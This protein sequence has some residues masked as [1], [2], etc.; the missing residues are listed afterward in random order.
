MSV[1][2][3]TKKD[4]KSGKRVFSSRVY[5]ADFVVTTPDGQRH[6]IRRSTG[7]KEK[8]AAKRV[9]AHWKEL[10]ACGELGFINE[11]SVDGMTLAEARWKFWEEVAQYQRSSASTAKNLEHICRLIG[12]HVRFVDITSADIADAARRRANESYGDGEH[13]RTVTL[14]TVNRQVVIPFRTLW[15]RA[16]RVW[17]P[18]G[19]GDE[20]LWGELLFEEPEERTRIFSEQES[21]IFWANLRD[22]YRPCLEFG[23]GRGLRLTEMIIRR[24]DVDLENNECVIRI[25]KKRGGSR[26]ERISLSRREKA[27]MA[28]AIKQ[29]PGEYLW[30]YVVQRGKLKGH[31]Q[32]IR[33]NGLKIYLR[34]YLANLRKEYPGLFIDF[35]PHDLRHDFATRLLRSTGNLEL[36]RK[37]LRHAD[38][39]STR[40]YAHVTGDDVTSAIEKVT[41]SRAPQTFPKLVKE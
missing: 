31:R 20:P 41:H 16:K 3:I 4:P 40:R 2:R 10:A 18:A 26:S 8:R 24:S 7:Q 34:R 17:K 25:A 12:G 15:R 13:K 28:T 9:V 29:A 36:V 33:L 22:D 32:P 38:I 23:V 5:Q 27:L 1:Y 21:E 30:T 37:A 11:W 39:Q 19:L 14:S 35:H 6:R